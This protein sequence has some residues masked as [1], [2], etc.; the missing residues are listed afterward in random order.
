[1]ATPIYARYV[2]PK[3]KV[4]ELELPGNI[5]QEAP[6]KSN[7]APESTS[8]PKRKRERSMSKKQNRRRPRR[9]MIR[10]T[11][12]KSSDRALG[13]LHLR[14]ESTWGIKMP[15]SGKFLKRE[16]NPIPEPAIKSSASSLPSWLASPVRVKPDAVSKFT[17]VGVQSDAAKFLEGKGFAGAFAVQAAV[18]PMLLPGKLQE[19]G[20]ILVSAAT[21]SGK[22]LAYVLPMIEDISHNIVT[23]ELVIQAKEVCE[24]CATA[25]NFG[26][27]R[28]VRI[29]VAIGSE[30]FATEQ[31]MIMEQQDRYAPLE[32]ENLERRLN[33]KWESSDWGSDDEEGIL[34]DREPISS[35]PDH[36]IDYVSKIDILICTPGRLVEHIKG[37]SGFTLQYTNWL[38][39][40]EADRL[41]DQSFQN[42]LGILLARLELDG[43]DGL[44]HRVRKCILSA[45]LT[46]D[47]GQLTGLK[48]YRPKL[49]VL[50]G[51]T[52]SLSQD[53]STQPES[54]HVLPSLLQE[55]GVK[56]E[57]DALNLKPLYLL[58]LLS[59]H[60][61]ATQTGTNHERLSDSEDTSDTESS[62]GDSSTSSSDSKE[63]SALTTSN[64][65][66][67]VLIFTKSNESA[68][69]LGRLIAL[70]EPNLSE[71]IGTLTSTTKSSVRK[72]T[73]KAFNSGKHSV[74]VASDLVSRGLDLPDLAHVIN[75]DMPTSVTNYV[76]R[77]GRTARAGKG[78][79]AW[80]IFTPAEGRWFW[81]E[82]SRTEAILRKDGCKIARVNIKPETFNEDVRRRYEKA[83]EELGK[84]ATSKPK[85]Q[86]KEKKK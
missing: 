73:I 11:R 65:P 21:G 51:V 62:S 12:P 57:E 55:F 2:P 31:A 46:K 67:G 23:R 53:S 35:L 69:R 43:H 58:E 13:K 37:T 36:I 16:K 63:V 76:H 8:M 59:R 64:M 17:D 74:L 70:I 14:S 39:V 25:F 28:R 82:I 15:N 77:V 47:L 10:Q 1:M 29:G 54:G 20:D 71:L 60:D 38:V 3:K 56:A 30:N 5:T 61:M 84:E 75:Y 9:K 68:V 26:N 83:L 80:T 50:E 7:D 33:R 34:C 4:Q 48:L 32:R 18:L 22:T 24:I 72:S 27:R 45:T 49:V 41:L 6:L 81:N 85:K 66:R 86:K 44:S 42:W 19:Q 52:S 78:G 79:S 40:D